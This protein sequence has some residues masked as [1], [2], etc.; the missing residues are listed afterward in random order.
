MLAMLV[1]VAAISAANAGGGPAET[2]IVDP[3][4]SASAQVSTLPAIVKWFLAKALNNEEKIKRRGWTRVP[5]PPVSFPLPLC[6]FEH[7]LCGAVNRDGS[8]AVAPRFDFVDDFHEGRAVVRLNGLYGYVDLNGKV[9][10][11]PQYTIAGRYHLGYAEVDVNGKSALIDL[12]GRQILEPRFARAGAFT[13]D[14]FWVNDGVRRYN[15]PPGGEIFAGPQP[16]YGPIQTIYVKG[17]W[18]LIDATGAWIREPEFS[19]IELFDRQQPNLSWAKTDAGW[20]LLRSDGT[21]LVEPTFERV[22]ELVDDRAPIWLGRRIG[23]VDRTGQIVIPPKFDDGVMLTHFIDGM[24]APAKLGRLFGLINPSGEW[25]VEPTYD[26]IHPISTVHPIYGGTAPASDPEFKGFVAQIGTEHRILDQFGNV[27]IGGMKLRPGT[28]TSR[29]TS[30]G[31]IVYTLS[32]GQ[33]PLVCEDGRIVGFV[34]EKPRLFEHDGTPL[35]VQGELWSSSCEVP[36]MV[37]IGDRF[38]YV[39]HS[40]HTL[41]AEKFD[42]V[43]R[44]HNGLAAVKL[45]G[46]HGLIRVD[47]SWAIEPKF[48]AAQPFESNTA[49]AK[50]DGRAGLVD[51]NTGGWI[52]RTSFDDVCPLGGVIGIVLNGKLGAVDEKG[53]WVFEPKFEQLHFVSYGFMPVQSDGKWGFVDLAGN[54]IETQFHEV[55]RFERGVAWVKNDGDWCLIDRR[56]NK[57][58]SVPC[59]NHVPRHIQRPEPEHAIT[60]QLRPI[61]PNQ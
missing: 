17:K 13:K 36:Y 61:G 60:C 42:A 49:L 4:P 2:P 23:Y 43:G 53:D 34:N 55:S 5:G 15:G 6:L 14:I 29:S 41:T 30:T 22:G 8:I 40:L 37:K 28:S 56:G 35:S 18:G 33:F 16:K 11:E 1:A 19:D 59:Q 44:F 21:W 9:V 20:G 46:K 7:G 10:V 3:A 45:A 50:I 25:V 39:D 38:G 24:P 12:D 27:I 52:T 26:R 31:D 32:P 54:T 51:I 58:P 57:V 47:G 48:D